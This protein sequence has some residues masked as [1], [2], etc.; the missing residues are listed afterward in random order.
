LAIDGATLALAAKI[1]TQSC[2]SGLSACRIMTPEIAAFARVE[3]PG[4]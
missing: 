1:R 3:N 4:A 2:F